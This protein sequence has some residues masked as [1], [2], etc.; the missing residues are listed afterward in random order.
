MSLPGAS[1]AARRLAAR[2]VLLAPLAACG[3]SSRDSAPQEVTVTMSEFD[4]ASS[5]TTFAAG[6]PYRFVLR[7]V[8]AAEHE[9]AV[10]PRG[11]V[12]EQQVLTEVEEDDLPPGATVTA[13]F[14]FPRAG[15]YDFACFVPGHFEAGMKLPVTV[16]ES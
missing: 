11:A 7:N 12:N 10:V 13:E 1:R 3:P 9:W 8:G 4:F 16:T 5:Q 2:L 14:T 15:E 6:T